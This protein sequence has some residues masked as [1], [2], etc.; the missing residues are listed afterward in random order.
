[1]PWQRITFADS[2]DLLFGLSSNL[3]GRDL[4]KAAQTLR[5]TSK[6]L[7][8]RAEKYNCLAEKIAGWDLLKSLKIGRSFF[9]IIYITFINCP[10]FP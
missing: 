7:R 3:M 6:K 4:G 2:L 10:L 5:T 9:F 1:M 8:E